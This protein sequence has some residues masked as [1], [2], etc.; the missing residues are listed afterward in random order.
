MRVLI[1]TGCFGLGHV[2]ASNAVAEEI[3]EKYPEAE[4][5]TVDLMKYLYPHTN[6]FIYC[7]LPYILR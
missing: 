5:F 4:V 7:P 3:T 6:K 2:S 1:L